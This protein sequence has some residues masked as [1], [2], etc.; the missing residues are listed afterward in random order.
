MLGEWDAALAPGAE[1]EPPPAFGL[2]W[3]PG[4]GPMRE[5]ETACLC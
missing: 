1:E 4:A 5:G 3:P 2:A